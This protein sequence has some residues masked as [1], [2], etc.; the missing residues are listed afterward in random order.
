MG[1]GLM[2]GI[3]LTQDMVRM[4]FLLQRM[5]HAKRPI[6]LMGSPASGKTTLLRHFLQTQDN[7]NKMTNLELVSCSHAATS[8][9][10]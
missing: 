4:T 6:L 8:G 1:K 10:T 9:N 5:F 2:S 3:V 7:I